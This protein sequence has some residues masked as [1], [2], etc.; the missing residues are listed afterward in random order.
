MFYSQPAGEGRRPICAGVGKTF[1]RA[2]P[3]GLRP[4]TMT[5]KARGPCETN[6]R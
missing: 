1:I 2:M 3:G 4:I 6:E 5:V